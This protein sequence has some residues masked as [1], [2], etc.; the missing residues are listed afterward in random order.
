MANRKLACRVFSLKAVDVAVLTSISPKMYCPGET[1]VYLRTK[2]LGL[3]SSYII[4]FHELGDT[5]SL[6][7]TVE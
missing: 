5:L 2:E 3:I 6:I 7:T 1:N 4:P